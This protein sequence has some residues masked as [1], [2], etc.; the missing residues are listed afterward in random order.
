MQK[1]ERATLC[2]GGLC[3]GAVPFCVRAACAWVLYR[4]APGW[5]EFGVCT[6]L[7]PGSLCQVYGGLCGERLP[8]GDGRGMI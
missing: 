3:L 4:S 5:P 8:A 7:C 1:R 6:V 2:P